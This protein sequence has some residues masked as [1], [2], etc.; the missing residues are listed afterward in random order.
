MSDLL[1]E[2]LAGFVGK[3]IKE[4]LH[5]LVERLDADTIKKV[6]DG[7]PYDEVRYAAGVSD[8]VQL[9]LNTV[10]ELGKTD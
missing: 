7:K 6:R 4:G 5:R 8:G 3:A 2:A 9:A 10:R 1:R